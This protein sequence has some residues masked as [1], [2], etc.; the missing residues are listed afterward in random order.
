MNG[1][2]SQN[3]LA[4]TEARDGGEYGDCHMLVTATCWRLP[5]AG[6]CHMLVIATYS[7]R[8]G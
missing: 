8:P 6:D 2:K 7:R 4:S 5:H 1:E 3:V